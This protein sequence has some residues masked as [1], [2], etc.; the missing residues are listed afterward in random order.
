MLE[1]RE[2]ST[3]FHTARG[4][5][6]AVN[7]VSFAVPGGR[8]VGIVGE[9]GCGKSVTIRSVLGLVRPPGR[10]TGGEAWFEGRNLLT[11]RRRELRR[12]LGSR[13]GFV[14]QQPFASLN[15]VLSI[16]EQFANLV[17]AHRSHASRSDIRALALRKLEET[18]IAGPEGVLRGYAHQLSGGMAQRVLIA[19][20]MALDPRLLIAD[21]PTSALDVTVQRQIL[22]LIRTLLADTDRSMLLVTHDLGVVA[23]YCDAVVVMYAGK[24]VEQGAV[25]DV[26]RLPRHPYTAALLRAV[27]RSTRQSPKSPRAVSCH[28]PVLEDGTA[29]VAAQT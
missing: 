5:I 14:G 19:M 25:R 28:H 21:E 23:Q 24:V 9:S 29:R 20:A 18:G 11:M 8:M 17:H 26:F 16:E 2:V 6:R 13:I 27:P 12:V 1:L 3:V 15:P 7:G 22:D 4:S 10:V